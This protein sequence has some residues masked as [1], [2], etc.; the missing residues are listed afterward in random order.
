[1]K[2]IF[3]ASFGVLAAISSCY[4]FFHQS[5]NSVLNNALTLTNVEALSNSEIIVDWD[6]CCAPGG[7]GCCPGPHYWLPN[8][9]IC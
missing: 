9:R 5:Q 7:D 8:D 2:K 4:G 1:M 6:R 3:L